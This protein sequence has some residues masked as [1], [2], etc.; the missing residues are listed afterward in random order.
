VASCPV[1]ALV[2]KNELEP[3][4]EVRTICPYCGVGC[5]IFLG[6]RGNRI[7][8]LRGDVDGPA[9]HGNLCVKG[10][11]GYDFIHSPD[12]LTTPLIR[13][14]GEMV[15]SS[16]DEA[17]GLIASKLGGYRGE[18]FAFIA[19]AKCT[20]EENYLFQKFTRGVMGTNSIDHCART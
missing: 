16:W 13:K 8:S 2:A 12:R 10:R 17:L 19:A 14:D 7:V 5:S 18:Q 4:H 20:N 6:V 3:E 1:G 11:F 15:A 9:N